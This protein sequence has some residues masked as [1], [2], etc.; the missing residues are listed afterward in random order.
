[1]HY[2]TAR[3]DLADLERRDL[4]HSRRVNKLKRYYPSN[5]LIK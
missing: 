4:L 5:K 3:N 2:L 1:V